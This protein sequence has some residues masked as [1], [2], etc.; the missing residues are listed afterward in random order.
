[1]SVFFL[2]RKK[3]SKLGNKWFVNALDYGYVF[4]LCHESAFKEATQ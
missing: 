2:I 3:L 1:M 4:F